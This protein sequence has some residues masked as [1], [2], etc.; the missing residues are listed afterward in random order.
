MINRE[1]LRK[2]LRDKED[3]YEE[4]VKRFHS[5]SRDDDKYA[6]RLAFKDII[7]LHE[8]IEKLTNTLS[9]VVKSE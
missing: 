5:A 1:S 8:Y 3:I 9:A 4:A 6:M 7:E 2:E